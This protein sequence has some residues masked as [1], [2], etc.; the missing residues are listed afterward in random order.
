MNRVFSGCSS[1]QLF[2]HIALPESQEHS[3][4]TRVSAVKIKEDCTENI[5]GKIST[6]FV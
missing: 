6:F 3:L 5:G 4:E 2:D 1:G